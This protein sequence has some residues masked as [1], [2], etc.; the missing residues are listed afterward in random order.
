MV[1][2]Q[3]HQLIGIDYHETFWH[4]VKP[5]IIHL[6]LSLAI[7]SHWCI[8][9]LDVKNGFLHRHLIGEVYMK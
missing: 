4:V 2:Q 8:R 6:I 5:A 9:Q 3:F 7:S 1:V